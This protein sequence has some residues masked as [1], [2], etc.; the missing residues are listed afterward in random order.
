MTYN[1]TPVRTAAIYFLLPSNVA[2][3]PPRPLGWPDSFADA[4]E[5]ETLAQE[6][7]YQYRVPFG[8][9]TIDVTLNRLFGGATR[10]RPG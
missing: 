7:E 4:Y 3:A 5:L 2:R 6:L 9:W 10:P 1:P 8:S